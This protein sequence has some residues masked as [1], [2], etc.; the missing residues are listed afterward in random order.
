M[1]PCTGSKVSSNYER[2]ASCA[3]CTKYPM[4]SQATPSPSTVSRVLTTRPFSS[5]QNEL[6]VAV[7]YQTPAQ[8]LADYSQE[9]SLSMLLTPCTDVQTSFSLYYEPIIRQFHKHLRHPLLS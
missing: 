5:H 8:Q 6:A 2:A 3:G 4:V 1:S 9:Q 7:G